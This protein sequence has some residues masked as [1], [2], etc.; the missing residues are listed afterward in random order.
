M[1]GYEIGRVTVFEGEHQYSIPSSIALKDYKY[2]LYWCKP[3]SVKVG[4]AQ[5]FED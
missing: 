4:D 1:G 3:F 2:I 5:L